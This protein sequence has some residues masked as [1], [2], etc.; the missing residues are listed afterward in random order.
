MHHHAPT[1]FGVWDT[2]SRLVPQLKASSQKLARNQ[3]KAEHL[4]MTH[5]HISASLTLIP[6]L[7]EVKLFSYPEGV[8]RN[9]VKLAQDEVISFSVT[10]RKGQY[11][12]EAPGYALN[13][14]S[15]IINYQN[16]STILSAISQ[17]N[18]SAE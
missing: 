11:R 15:V 4:H 5:R 17:H 6:C 12:M 2:H 7:E 16:D 13:G 9:I 10:E 18:L 8:S 3:D 14:S 1:S